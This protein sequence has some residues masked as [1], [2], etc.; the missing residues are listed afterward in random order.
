[1][2]SAPTTHRTRY[3]EVSLKAKE[4]K[5]REIVMIALVRDLVLAPALPRKLRRS[6]QCP[7]DYNIVSAMFD[8]E[9]WEPTYDFLECSLLYRQRSKAEVRCH[10]LELSEFFL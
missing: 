2:I 9:I 5:F 3:L 4:W 7:P 8:P 6:L 10:G 1:M